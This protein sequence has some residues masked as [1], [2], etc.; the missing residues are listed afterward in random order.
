M[1]KWE[2]GGYPN[3]FKAKVLAWYE[4]HKLVILHTEDAKTPKR[5]GRR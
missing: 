4:L 3:W 5:K 1:H 2:L